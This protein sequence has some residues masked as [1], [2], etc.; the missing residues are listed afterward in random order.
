MAGKNEDTV[1]LSREQVS[2]PVKNRPC[3]IVVEGPALGKQVRLE[4]DELVI[5]RSESADISLDDKLLSREH[6]KLIATRHN[7]G[8][9]YFIE[10]LGSTNGTYLNGLRVGRSSLREG[11][12]IHL[13]GTILRFSF[14]DEIDSAY[15][16]RIYDMI[17]YDD[18][19]G[20]FT[21]RFFYAEMDKELARA[22]RSGRPLSLLMMDLD[23]F[24]RVNDTHGHQTGSYVL[25]EVGRLIRSSLRSS[26]MAG[27]YGGEEF[28]A[29]L[30]GAGKDQSKVCANRIRSGIAR[31]NFRYEEHTPRVTI[32]IGVSTYPADGRTIEALVKR[33][34]ECL[35]RAKQTGRNRVC[36]G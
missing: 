26:D 16:R 28:I 1:S 24:K 4:A 17:H 34:D 29:F 6:A 20:L 22:D 15:Q 7:G 8:T 3:V 5:G 9:E 18:L 23:H 33:A 12:K 27:R 2:V 10:D 14:H 30:S 25:K 35:Y 11:D 21:L 19:T 36:C 13:G 32:S 31:F